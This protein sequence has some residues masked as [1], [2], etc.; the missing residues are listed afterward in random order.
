[1]HNTLNLEATGCLLSKNSKLR[2]EFALVYQ[3]WKDWK[4][5]PWSEVLLQQLNDEGQDVV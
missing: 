5:V 2:L 4:N 3:K 1:M